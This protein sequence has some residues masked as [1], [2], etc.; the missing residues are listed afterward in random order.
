M[1]RLVMR[2]GF[3]PPTGFPVEED[4]PAGGP[5]NAGDQIEDGGLARAV[6][7]DEADQFARADAEVETR[8]G[9]QPAE[10][11]GDIAQVQQRFGLAHAFFRFR[12]RSAAEEPLR[13][14]QHQDDQQQRIKDHAVRQQRAASQCGSKGR[15]GET[16]RSHL[17][18]D[19]EQTS[20][21]CTT[22]GGAAHAAQDDH[23]HDIHRFH[24]IESLGIDEL[25]EVRVKPA[26]DAREERR[27]AQRRAPCIWSC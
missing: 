19:R 15:I 24:E 2:Y 9:L 7:A 5:I 1:P 17:R 6:R 14:R 13:P 20:P 11:D 26:G 16:S 10:L 18:Q 12:L 27:R 21:R 25:L 3:F 4:A 23:H 22:P 8:H